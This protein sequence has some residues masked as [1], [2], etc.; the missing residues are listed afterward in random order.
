MR[1]T[2]LALFAACAVQFAF[3]APAYA[4]DG[5][6]IIFKSGTV[7]YMNNGYQQIAAALVELNKKGGENYTT[8]VKI[9]DATF[10]INL[11]AVAIVCR[12]R[13]SSMQI[14]PKKETEKEG[15]AR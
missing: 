4:G 14:I 10:H 1:L 7:V 15:P 5:A 3:A 2:I 9:E 6:T 8:E 11:G 12:D 13:C